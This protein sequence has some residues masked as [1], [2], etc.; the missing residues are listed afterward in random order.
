M[1]ANVNAI[2]AIAANVCFLVELSHKGPLGDAQTAQNFLISSAPE[3]FM[4][5]SKD[6]MLHYAAQGCG[7]GS[8]SER[9]RTAITAALKKKLKDVMG[10]FGVLRQKLQ[11]EYRCFSFPS[12]ELQVDSLL[13]VTFKLCQFS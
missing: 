13:A 9:T 7:V 1:G 8:S 3:T 12:H 10:E 11:Q 5:R 6:D 2:T 4:Q